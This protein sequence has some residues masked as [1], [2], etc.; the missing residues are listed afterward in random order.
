M[1]RNYSNIVT[2]IWGK[3]D[4]FKALPSS[5]QR[6]YLMLF[7]Q[8]DISAAGVLAI[9]LTR[10]ASYAADTSVASILSDVDTLVRGSYIVLDR[11][12]DE[13][14]VRSFI[15][16]DKGYRNPKRRPVL[17]DAIANV[18]S[19]AIRAAID[20]E[21]ARLDATPSDV[22]AA[23]N[24]HVNT[25]FDTQSDTLSDRQFQKTPM[26]NGAYPSPQSPDRNPDS[27]RS[28][29]ARASTKSAPGG[30]IATRTTGAAKGSRIPDDFQVT[31]E[32]REWAKAKAPR[33]G[34]A[35]HEAFVDYYKAAPGAKGVKLDWVATWRNWMRKENERRWSANGRVSPRPS[36]TDAAVAQTLALAEEM[37]GQPIPPRGEITS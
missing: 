7:S 2:D 25:L 35:D 4:D 18:Q 26:S 16:W 20:V 33:C 34:A 3:D 8:R 15:R 17:L 31:D 21:L 19:R 27:L 36:T 29:S 24:P 23:A 14:L 9:T 28:S 22:E 1:A 37:D 10:W 13:I 12:T 6:V 5:A 30:T 11:D 32:M